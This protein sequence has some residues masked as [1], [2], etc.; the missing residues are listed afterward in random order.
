MYTSHYSSLLN[1]KLMQRYLFT[2]KA[3]LLP[4]VSDYIS[5]PADIR[6]GQQPR[7]GKQPAGKLQSD[8]DLSKGQHGCQ[9]GL[10]ER[11]QDSCRLWCHSLVSSLVSSLVPEREKPRGPCTHSSQNRDVRS[12]G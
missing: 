8:R 5:I 2:P 3:C 11:S 6:K 12:S 4:V 7:N 9:H 1:L 10:W